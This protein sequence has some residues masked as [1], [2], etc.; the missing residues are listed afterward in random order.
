MCVLPDFNRPLPQIDRPKRHPFP[1]AKATITFVRI[2][3]DVLSEGHAHVL[4]VSIDKN[5]R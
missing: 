1:D 5:M 2:L 4:E 3:S